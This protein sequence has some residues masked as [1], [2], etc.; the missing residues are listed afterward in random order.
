[1]A[2][3]CRWKRLEYIEV[4]AKLILID[5][6]N[7]NTKLNNFKFI[8]LCIRIPNANLGHELGTLR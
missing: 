8:I 2:Y 5:I 3:D 6:S 1:M 4:N 7:G